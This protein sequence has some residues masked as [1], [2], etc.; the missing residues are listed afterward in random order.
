MK[1]KL[2]FFVIFICCIS[3][4]DT[5]NTPENISQCNEQLGTT[6]DPVLF[7][8][9]GYHF[10]IIGDT[11][12]GGEGQIKAAEILES[13]HLKYPLNAIIHT[14]DVFYP[15]GISSSNSQTTYDKFEA[16]YSTHALSHVP[17]Y[18]VA[19][20]H[21]YHGSIDAL[22]N[23]SLNSDQ[24]HYPSRYY[25]KNIS[26]DSIDWSINL[27]ATDTTPFTLG[28]PQAEQLAWIEQQLFNYSHQVNLV[29]GHHPIH[30]NGHHG[31]TKEL[32]GIFQQLLKHYSATMYLSGHEHSLQLLSKEEF[33]YYLIS[34]AGGAELTNVA[35]KEDTLFSRK[36][37]GGFG[38]YVTREKLWVIPV[39]NDEPQIMFS[40]PLKRINSH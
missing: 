5:N 36:A 19:G 13:Y 3:C 11:G 4:K 7:Q 37:Y 29:F 30:S 14:G 12:T 32:Q 10:Y 24:I 1:V 2:L 39:T 26:D 9:P 15:N 31:S 20:N 33:E 23:Y 35:C 34:G 8:T 40:L 38:L 28:D 22:I 6:F 27:I 16:I 18:I 25:I 21:D 17:W